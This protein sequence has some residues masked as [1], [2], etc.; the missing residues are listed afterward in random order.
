MCGITGHVVLGGSSGGCG[1]D[2]LADETAVRVAVERMA[3][4]GPDETGRHETARAALGIA[5]LRVIGLADGSQPA[6]DA[7]GTVA[8]VV[9][10]EIYNHAAL[11]R[12]LAEAG[13]PVPAGSDVHVVPE[14]Y[15]LLGPRFVDE[16]H[17]MF[18]IALYDSRSAT[19][20]LATDRAG[21]KPLCYTTLPDGSVAFASE[22][23]A[24]LA[25][26]GIDRAIDPIALDAY[27]SYRIVPAPRTI[28]RAVRKVP[29]ATVL[30]FRA[31][32]APAERRYWSFDFTPRVAETDPERLADEIETRLRTAV[33]DRLESEVP[34]GSMLSGGL[35]SSLVVALA[36]QRLRR[37]IHTFSV[38]FAQAAFDESAHARA[39]AAH[40]GT[41]HHAY[42]IDAA[43]AAAAIDPILRHVGEPYAFPSAIASWY[44]YRLAGRYV[45][46]VLTGDG[47]DEIFC[48]YDR[49]RR[50]LRLDES[51]GDIAARY[52]SVLADGVRGPLKARLYRR[53]F[54]DLLPEPFPVDHLAPRFAL[55][56]PDAAPLDRAMQVD[57][58]F[59]LP[60]AQLVKIDRMAMAHSVE[61][62]SPMLD[63]RLVEYV[64][65]I[66]AAAKLAGGTEKA[67]LKRVARRHLPEFVLARRK[68]ELAVPLADWL[69]AALRP[70]VT[71]T[72]LSDRA[73]DRGYFEPDVLRELVTAF[74]PEDSYAL[75]TL[76]MLERWHELAV[77]APVLAEAGAA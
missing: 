67:L 42:R 58:G 21:K 11:R 30:T 27:L 23:Q 32:A 43:D 18:A 36:T 73:L 9:N 54:R 57:C 47:S 17:G 50:F 2:A 59:W 51:S 44:M 55:T 6:Y 28:Y 22:I 35:D 34:L 33:A 10:G 41:E 70:T 68:Q 29:P 64:T 52:E 1:G 60:D 48:G 5:R 3:H 38:G 39:V 76:F 72:L 16:L 77:D 40:C 12:R 74:R 14:L 26:P 65:G 66:P 63:H 49:Y 20:L 19:L 24:L 69:G 7:S 37:R 61:P 75:W 53:T 71:A 56:D 46:V 4:R 31:G 15:R 13:R 62:R 25:Y 8:C 45:T